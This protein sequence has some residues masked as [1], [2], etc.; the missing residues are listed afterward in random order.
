MTC[1]LQAHNAAPLDRNVRYVYYQNEVMRLLEV[2]AFAGAPPTT[3]EPRIAVCE[4]DRAE[5]APFLSRTRPTIVIHPGAG[6]VRRRWPPQNFAKVGQR[7]SDAGCEVVV[8]GAA[9]EKDLAAEVAAGTPRSK[10]ASGRL[11]LAGLTGLVAGARLVVS[12][13][14]GP[15]HLAAATGTATV[16]VYWCGNAIN[17]APADRARHRPVLSFRVACSECGARTDGPGCSH[18]SSFVDLAPLDEVVE[19]ALDLLETAPRLVESNERRRIS[20]Y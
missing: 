13:D 9:E 14:S 18:S 3:F 1:G 5:A 6:D 2:A 7:L 8:T 11:T 10:D 19:H 12:N 20:L 17:A 16:G 15:L 4:P